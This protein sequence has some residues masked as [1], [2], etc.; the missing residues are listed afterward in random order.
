MV[1]CEK[2]LLSSV[3]GNS[4]QAPSL[5]CWLLSEGHAG[6]E[7]QCRGLAEALELDPVLKRVRA[8]FPW[9]YFPVQLWWRP[10]TVATEGDFAPPWPDILISCGRRSVAVA[11]AVQRASASKTF[12]V[13]IQDPHVASYHF[14]LVVVPQHD[15]LRGDNVLVT[16]GALHIG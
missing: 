11:L 16:R 1:G 14:D 5:T 6:M 12:T 8:K 4:R 7:N 3:D 13:H 2:L 9:K 10:L 15:N